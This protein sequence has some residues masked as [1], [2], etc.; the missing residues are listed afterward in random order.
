[1][2]DPQVEIYS[3]LRNGWLNGFF[4]LDFRKEGEGNLA[5]MGLV[6]DAV[7]TGW[8]TWLLRTAVH[9]LWDHDGTQRLTV[10]TCTLDHPRAL[11]HYQRQGFSPIGQ[12]TR[13]RV[14]SRDWDPSTFP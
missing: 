14:L 8:G 3:F 12:E 2:A 7:G 11:S 1:V 13:T 6:P 4:C 9:M 5:Y 10:N